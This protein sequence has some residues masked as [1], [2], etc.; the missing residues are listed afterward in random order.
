MSS[1]A[2]GQFFSEDALIAAARELRSR[3]FSGLEL[4]SPFPL[5]GAAQVLGLKPPRLPALALGG[6]LTGAALA[7]LIQWYCDAYDWPLV[8][9]GHPADAAPAFIPITFETAVLFAAASAFF[10]ALWGSGL[11]KLGHPVFDHDA[12]RS[13]TEGGFWANVSAGDEGEL[14]RALEALRD[15]GAANVAEVRGG[16]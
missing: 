2:L 8:T 10:G 7:Y 15:L 14:Q 13:V 16:R 5:E 4:H 6:G 12:F 11:P 1:H 9:G 3:G